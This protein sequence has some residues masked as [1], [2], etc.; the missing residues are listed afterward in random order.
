MSDKQD[1]LG[2]TAFMAFPL[3]GIDA[4]QPFDLQPPGTTPCAVN[5]C[6]VDPTSNRARG[7]S[8]PGLGRFLPPLPTLSG[9]QSLDI[10]VDPQADA[11]T[12]DFGELPIGDLIQFEWI[13]DPTT[14]AN[15]YGR[16]RN[17][18]QVKK[19]G[20]GRDTGF[21]ISKSPTKVLWS[22]PA[23]MTAG[24]PLSA[25][26]LNASAVEAPG[27]IIAVAGT[28]E[29]SPASGTVLSVGHAT[30]NV[31]FTPTDEDFYKGSIGRVSVNVTKSTPE[32]V[33]AN[34]A[35]ID[36]ATPL[37]STQL[38]ATARHP[39]TLVTIAG[40]FTYTPP[41]GTFLSEGNGQALS[42]HFV[43][44]N[45]A[46][47]DT[48]V[49]KVVHINVAA[50]GDELGPLDIAASRCYSAGAGPD[51]VSTLELDIV[52]NGTI[53]TTAKRDPGTVAVPNTNPDWGSV[54]N[55]SNVQFGATPFP[56]SVR[57]V[58]GTQWYYYIP[59]S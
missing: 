21:S 38:N 47:Y 12:A 2:Q 31:K 39:I 23:D 1:A 54:G 52:A 22:D 46:A 57:L 34:P 11:L 7:G 19:G 15:R 30:L 56:C 40:E 45:T 14:G 28:M 26:Q 37:S 44:S 35:D 32:L 29:Y 13:D 58:D 17:L 55:N 42:A 4:E 53:T 8:R 43:P 50:G 36:E 59:P 49:D 16:Q 33:W 6:S 48:P 41:S 51:F 25:T 9:I 18:G 27:G 24:E 20:S 10:I 3:G 5:V